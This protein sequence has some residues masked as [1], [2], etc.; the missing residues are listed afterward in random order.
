MINEVTKICKSGAELA[1][2][3][4]VEKAFSVSNKGLRNLVTEADL[5]VEEYLKTELLKITPQARFLAEETSNGLSDFA[6]VVWIVDPI[7][8]TTNFTQGLPHSAVSVALAKDGTVVLGVVVNILTG[9]TFA[10]SLGQGATRD[11]RLIPKVS[12]NPHGLFLLGF[13]NSEGH[14]FE[15]SFE[16]MRRLRASVHEFRRLGAAS[17]DT[18][19]VACGIAV[20]YLESVRPWD[21]AAG[22]LIA[23][24]AGCFVGTYTDDPLNQTLPEDLKSFSFLVAHPD[25]FESIRNALNSPPA[26]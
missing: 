1:K 11:G 17:L 20:A 19:Y 18:C 14:K 8:G 21:I 24:E 13:L 5:A 4:Y 3:L 2:R 22:A 15:H 9:E 26:N 6:G 23:R 10:A 25:R 16:V 7:D 12:P